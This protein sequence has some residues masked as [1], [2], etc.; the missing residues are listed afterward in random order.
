MGDLHMPLS[1]VSVRHLPV[2]TPPLKGFL[3]EGG[4]I[5]QPAGELAQI[6]NGGSFQYLAY[7]EFNIDAPVLRGNHY[8]EIKEEFLY[9]LTGKLR[10]VYKDID[11]DDMEEITV[12]AG[13]LIT[14]QPRCAHVYF[15]IEYSQAIE[16]SAS[17]YDPQDT[18]KYVLADMLRV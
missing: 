10:A 14:I 6:T 11:T 8:H 12:S 15:P 5:K 16:F 9:I 4:R 3:E 18:L 2:Y 7:I 13:D 17:L 1:K